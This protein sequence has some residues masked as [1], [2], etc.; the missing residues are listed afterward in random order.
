[1]ANPR[2][3]MPEP[4]VFP[5]D[6]PFWA[7]TREGQL[8]AKRCTACDALHFYPRAHCP[9]CGH[10]ETLWH[11]LSG[12]G[13]VYSHTVVERSPRPTAPAIIE[14]E[15]GLRI[16]SVVVDADV[17]ALRIGDPVTL[18]CI[19]TEQG[20]FLPA[21]T[22][23]AAEQARAYTQRA[24]AALGATPPEAAQRFR[25]AVVI[26]AG[27]MGV[28]IAL[29]LL[30]GGLRV[31]LIDK[32]APALASA[33]E[34]IAAGLQQQVD[35]GRLSAPA[36]AEQQAALTT[37]T[38]VTDVAHAELV[39]EAVF[40]DMALKCDIFRTID[41]HADAGAVLAT[42]TSTLDI[43]QIA[44][45][46]RRPE[47]VVGLHFFN[48]AQVM[49]LLEIVRAPATSAD[50]LTAAKALAQ[51]IGKTPI[52]VGICNGF[53]GNRLM[54]TRERQAAQ[55][56]LE[57]ALPEQ[58]DRFQ[59]EFGLPMGTFE[60][61]D[62]AGGIT[63]THH[64]RQRSGQSDW[65]VEQLFQRG[66]LGQ[67][68]GRG[69]YRYEAGKRRPL[70]DPEVTALIEEASRLKGLERRAIGEQELH[71][72]LIL[73]MVNEGAK[74]V[75]EGIVERAS[76]ID[77]VWQL[78][79]GW[80]D[81]KGGPMHHADTLGLATVVERLQALQAR[82]GPVFQPAGALV[83]LAQRGGRFCEQTS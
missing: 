12:R 48:P 53:V 34:R 77:L 47:A 59:R 76:D 58:I 27:N 29:A 61:Q 33:Q 9:H 1:M 49:K 6:E 55:L 72:R 30:A 8:L 4:V 68:A 22:T 20:R 71:D 35:R 75:A 56:L 65:L 24:R 36:M 83:Q 73:P 41:A 69:Y 44:A 70:V 15:E 10:R 60:L 40:E 17:H 37:S 14:L 31:R 54:I 82:H 67:R 62:M 21:F 13:T 52:V 45:A 64:A 43:G 19:P 26:G 63:L 79:Y 78:G 39:L 81:W 80:P 74:L 51:R 7:A 2:N 23:L 32:S 25:Q 66:R 18:R 42:N 3:F 57:G 38:E 46:T 16:H 50:T 11:A 5:G 28:G